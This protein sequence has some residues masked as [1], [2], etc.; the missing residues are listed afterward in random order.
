MSGLFERGPLKIK[1]SGRLLERERYIPEGAGGETHVHVTTAEDQFVRV[2]NILGGGTGRPIVTKDTEVDE[3]AIVVI[4][5]R[6]EKEVFT[7]LD[8]SRLAGCGFNVRF[9]V[10]VRSTQIF[11]IRIFKL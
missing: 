6:R 8:I 11:I 7:N 5:Q 2:L 1:L 10:A 9:V 3:L 4:A